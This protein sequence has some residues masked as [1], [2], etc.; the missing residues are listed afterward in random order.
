VQIFRRQERRRLTPEG[1]SAFVLARN[2]NREVHRAPA[3]F[4]PSEDVWGRAR[5]RVRAHVYL[6]DVV[7][8]EIVPLFEGPCRPVRLQE[9]ARD[10]AVW[11]GIPEAEVHLLDRNL[12]VVF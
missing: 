6:Y 1:P 11:L 7:T 10:I 4:S 9:K 12:T 2:G 3:H 8:K 5:I